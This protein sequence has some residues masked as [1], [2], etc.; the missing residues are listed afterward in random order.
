MTEPTNIQEAVVHHTEGSTTFIGE[1][2][3]ALYRL[4]GLIAMA[5]AEL[6]WLENHGTRFHMQSCPLQALKR[7]LDLQSTTREKIAEEFNAL[8]EEVGVQGLVDRSI[9]V[10]NRPRPK[11]PEKVP[12]E[13]NCEE[14][15]Y[16]VGGIFDITVQNVLDQLVSAFEGGTGYWC[17]ILSCNEPSDPKMIPAGKDITKYCTPWGDGYMTLCD[18]EEYYA[19]EAF[20]REHDEDCPEFDGE[21]WRL[22]E[23][24]MKRGLDVMAKEY[25]QHFKNLVMEQGDADTADVWLQCCLFGKLVYG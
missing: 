4:T 1:Q 24:A 13:R 8:L 14:V 10:S 17:C 3:V 12:G 23:T 2:G 19:S 18:V 15:F 5:K 16:S 11:R 20:Q 7:E 9:E 25:K 22:D 6:E 21:T